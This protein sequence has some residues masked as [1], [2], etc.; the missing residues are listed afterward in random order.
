MEPVNRNID[1]IPGFGEIIQAG[2]IP[3]Q[4][5]PEHYT[6][7]AN[8]AKNI[9][10]LYALALQDFAV[11]EKALD[12][13]EQGEVHFTETVDDALKI[14]AREIELLNREITHLKNQKLEITKAAEEKAKSAQ[15]LIEELKQEIT[16]RDDRIEK[17]NSD[18]KLT[19]EYC[20]KDE[21]QYLSHLEK[22]N[23]LYSFGY[24]SL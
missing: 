3:L 11:V 17:M 16:L 9:Y 8:K 13:N 20:E 24:K 14:A 1:I 21:K 2:N 7:L 22:I 12:D 18:L 6:A 23:Q 5:L 10:N 4:E 19:K 15:E